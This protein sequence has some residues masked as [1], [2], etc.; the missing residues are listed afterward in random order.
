MSQTSSTAVGVSEPSGDKGRALLEKVWEAFKA[1]DAWPSVDH[2]DTLLFREGVHLEEALAELSSD[3]VH[4]VNW[5]MPV[6]VNTGQ[7]FELT[8]AGAFN[9]SN[10]EPE[11]HMY[12]RLV[13]LATEIECG[14]RAPFT[15]R[16]L[17]A[18]TL[19]D[20]LGQNSLPG[21][22]RVIYRAVLLAGVEPAFSGSSTNIAD[23]R[24]SLNFD[25]RIRAF[26]GV[27]DTALA[28]WTTRQG[29]LAPTPPDPVFAAPPQLRMSRTPPFAVSIPLHP[30]VAAVAAERFENGQHADAV[31][32]AF[33]AV[34]HRVQS[35]SGLP[36]VGARLM[37]LALGSA[38]PM[39]VVTRAAGPSLPSEREG[40]RDLFKGAMTGLR[41]P[42]AHGPHYADDPEEAQEMLAFASLLMR[43]LDHAE[44]ELNTQ[45]AQA[46][47]T[48]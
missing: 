45:A 1:A 10:S 35:L 31:M 6:S 5:N 30:E 44:D 9:C 46:A 25:R 28:Y 11:T 12:L 17:D 48:P 39:L 42:R 18:E 26:V 32:R 7:T 34:E 2:I 15:A 22:P 24:W 40:F 19:P 4:G 29:L 36:E 13:D 21:D 3:L 43:R 8:F 47:G 33:Q 38:T 37:G 14:I 20:L 27:A 23:Y 16:T 41:N